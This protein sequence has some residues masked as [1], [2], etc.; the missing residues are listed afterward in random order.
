M[1]ACSLVTDL[2]LGAGVVCH[3]HTSTGN[4]IG[5]AE[6][7]IDD[8]LRGQTHCREAHVW[9]FHHHESGLR[10]PNRAARQSQGLQ[11]DMCGVCEVMTEMHACRCY[12]F[13]NEIPRRSLTRSCAVLICVRVCVCICFAQ[14]LFR[15][16]ACMIPD[17]RLIA[18]VVL[19]SEGFENAKVRRFTI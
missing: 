2:F 8:V 7:D 17:Y 6:A 9:L 12:A 10:R 16:V 4:P 15:P 1:Y 5:A 14:S 11:T 3:R 13:E 18:E 19:F